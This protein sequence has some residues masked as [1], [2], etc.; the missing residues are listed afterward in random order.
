MTLE[1]A[2]VRAEALNQR[3]SRHLSELNLPKPKEF[4]RRIRAY[5]LH[6]REENGHPGVPVE[7]NL[8]LRNS[9]QDK[10]EINLG[11]TIDKGADGS[12]F[13]LKFRRWTIARHYPG[14]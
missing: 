9:G 8:R 3:F 10:Y 1:A 5:L 12:E 7:A 14:R 11:P 2:R 6:Q 4:T 13:I